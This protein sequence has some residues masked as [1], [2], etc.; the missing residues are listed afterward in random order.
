M[1]SVQSVFLKNRDI[2]NSV[3][4]R[5]T[6]LELCLAA[7]RTAG[8]G[9]VVGA[10]NI[11]GLWRVYPAT[12]QAR[13]DLLV[14]G[15][16]VRNTVLQLSNNNP[17][18]LKDDSGVE[19]PATKVWVADI[20]MSVANSEIEHSLTQIGCEFRS[21]I[22]Q[23]RYR[24][25][26]S[27]LTRFETGR[28]FVFITLPTTPLEKTLKVGPFTATIFHKEQPKVVKSVT[29]SK[30][31]Q[32]NHHVSVCMNEVVCRVC[33]QPGH[34]RG[35][36][37]CEEKADTHVQARESVPQSQ[38]QSQPGL[39]SQ[40]GHPVGNISNTPH[41][42]RLA[43]VGNKSGGKGKSSGSEGNNKNRVRSEPKKSDRGRAATKKQT[44][45]HSTMAPRPDPHRT[46]SET[47][48]RP[49]SRDQDSPS[50][51]TEKQARCDKDIDNDNDDYELSDAVSD[52]DK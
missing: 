25:A 31:L 11:R 44:T 49:R 18:M 13:N 12:K 9:T 27:K 46:R 47:P 39:P 22:K 36:P 23:E 8:N 37:L 26:D 1:S 42:W 10:Q 48:K 34:K 3:Q 40:E 20:P 29:C 38:P 41:A 45:L 50:A 30:C 15:M 21:E 33:K 2:P 7:E 35:D 17:F 6:G 51:L 24:D 28:R 32:P 52:N 43:V 5:V 16:T 19:K 14:R 4:N